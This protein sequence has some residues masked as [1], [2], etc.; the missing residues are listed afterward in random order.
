MAAQMLPAKLKPDMLVLATAI[1]SASNSWR[2]A[3][4]TG[5]KLDWPAKADRRLPVERMLPDGSCLSTV[6]DS[7]DKRRTSG[8]ILRVIEYML[9]DSAT[10]TEGSY[11]LVTN[12]LDPTQAP[13]QPARGQA[14]DEQ[15]QRP[16]SG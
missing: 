8:Q 9:E 2:A 4:A 16:R 5:A 11:R 12:I 15:L 6:F 7:E 10:P 14:Q 13:L 1:S 3:C